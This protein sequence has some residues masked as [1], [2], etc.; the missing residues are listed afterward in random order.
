MPSFSYIKRT[1][2]RYARVGDNF[3]AGSFSAEYEVRVSS[4]PPKTPWKERKETVLLQQIAAGTVGAVRDGCTLE[5]KRIDPI[6][7]KA[8]ED[9]TKNR[10]SCAKRQKKSTPANG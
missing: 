7:R 9:S 8:L 10:R 6:T 3:D 2:P 4:I 1:L 5:G